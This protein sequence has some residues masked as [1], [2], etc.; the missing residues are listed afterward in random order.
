M[1]G[2]DISLEN[3]MSTAVY[4]RL[5]TS[6]VDT[7]LTGPV[8]HLQLDLAVNSSNP[9]SKSGAVQIVQEEGEWPALRYSGLLTDLVLTYFLWSFSEEWGVK[10]DTRILL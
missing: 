7:I 1:R 5:S 9:W 8:M 3:F 10:F 2:S 4:Q 6:D